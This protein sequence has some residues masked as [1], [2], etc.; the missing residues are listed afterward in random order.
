[1]RLS[2]WKREE[3]EVR[4]MSDGETQGKWEGGVGGG[5]GRGRAMV[6]ARLLFPGSA[7]AFPCASLSLSLA[8]ALS[9]RWS[10]AGDEAGVEEAKPNPRISPH[11]LSSPLAV[12]RGLNAPRQLRPGN[13]V[14]QIWSPDP[15]NQ[16]ELAQTA[17]G[18]AH[19]GSLWKALTA[20]RSQLSPL[21][22]SPVCSAL[23]SPPYLT[24]VH[25]AVPGQVMGRGNAWTAVP[26]LWKRDSQWLRS[27][28]SSVRGSGSPSRA[29]STM[30]LSVRP[31]RR[32]LSRSIT[33]SQSFAGVN[34][35]DKPYRNLSVFSTPA[36]TRKTP[37]RASRMSYLQVHQLELD[38][39]NRQ[40]RESKRNSRLVRTWL[41]LGLASILRVSDGLRS[42]L[43]R[44]WG[45]L[46]ELDKQVKV[47]E[48]FMRRLE[49][50][51]SKVRH[52]L[53]EVSSVDCVKVYIHIYVFVCMCM[54]VDKSIC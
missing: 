45:F 54:C 40:M 31:S 53:P 1:M 15:T 23:W 11:Q 21:S 20:P 8:L 7:S 44:D 25:T 30:S 39:L 17:P 4:V 18:W 14:Q 36:C 42:Y 34:S 46:Y 24:W 10:E 28:T 37:S 48:R 27:A 52:C 13:H 12:R 6:T 47:I 3:Q 9:L 19:H 51:L 26:V 5:R 43:G 33:R 22:R 29:V 50:H 16:P 32:I 49:F 38:S 41:S 2:S 35:H